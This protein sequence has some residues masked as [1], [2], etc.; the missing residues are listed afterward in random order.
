MLLSPPVKEKSRTSSHD[1]A[2][3]SLEAAFSF[4]EAA[5]LLVCD[6]GLSFCI[7][8]AS[9]QDR[10]RWPEPIFV[11]VGYTFIHSFVHTFPVSLVINTVGLEMGGRAEA[12]SA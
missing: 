6:R 1:A 8:I 11:R 5:I 10:L 4:I 3:A 9:G 12:A 7:A 2:H